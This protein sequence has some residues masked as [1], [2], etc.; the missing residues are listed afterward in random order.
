MSKI[1]QESDGGRSNDN[2][3]RIHTTKTSVVVSVH[4]HVLHTL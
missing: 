1:K 2:Q 4:L 3:L